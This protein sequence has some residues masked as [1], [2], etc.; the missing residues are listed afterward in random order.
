MTL[1][2]GIRMNGSQ[3]IFNKIAEA[4]LI[5]YTS[6]YYVNA[7]TNE[8]VWYSEDEQYHSLCIAQQGADFFAD[9]VKDAD[10]V[11]YEE[12]KHIFMKDMTKEN[13]LARMEKGE[14]QSIEYRLM[15][16]GKPVY[17]TVRLI[18]GPREGDEYFILGVINIDEEV[19]RRQKEQ[20]LEKE[21]R[22]YNQI[23][24]SL[25]EHYDT[26]YYVDIETDD[27]FEV[28][29]S[30]VYKSLEIKPSG[31]DFFG[32]SARNLKRAIYPEDA[33][34][35]L[36]LFT[37]Q[38]IIENLK[39]SKTFTLTYRL[40]VQGNVMNVRCSQIWANDRKHLILCIENINDEVS[41]QQEL[42]ESKRK[43]MTYGQIAE[44]LA[45]HYDVIY[46][47]DSSNDSYTG[48]TI[49]SIFGSLYIKE[50]GGD[51]FAEAWKNSEQIIYSED[52]DR[53]Q[54]I[55]GKDYLIS[56]LEDKK[57]FVCDYRMV[58]DGKMT[59]NRMTIMWASDRVHFIIGVQNIDEE[60]KKEK[61]QV[62]AL[63]RANELARRDDLTGIRNK[64]AYHELEEQVQEIIDEGAENLDFAI[65]VCDINGLKHV[66]DT[67][68]HKAGDEYIRS[69]CKIICNI[70]THS[71]V[72]RIGGDEFVV[73]IEK[74]SYNDRHSLLE[75]L[76]SQVMENLKKKSGP[77]IAAGM[78]YFE[79]SSDRKVS[80]VFD[81]AD[82][83]MYENKSR[84]KELSSLNVSEIS[85]TGDV[86]MPIPKERSIILDR[87][88]EALSVISDSMFIF[89]C[90]LKH[91]YSRWSKIGVEYFGMPSEYMYRA[92]DIWVEKIHPDDRATY[93]Q[94]MNALF[95][96]E[97][98][99]HN[100][101]YRA[102]RP[103]GE[104]D[105][106][107]CR[108]IVLRDT[109]GTPDY[110]C[111]SI[112]N[113]NI[114]SHV[115]RL[116][117]LRNQY[118][119]FED[120]QWA[121]DRKKPGRIVL[122][123]ISRFSEINEI[124]GY[125]FG[126]SVLQ[127][128]GRYL[129]ESAGNTG[130]VYRLDGT[131]FAIM[132]KIPA[133]EIERRYHEFRTAFRA[134][135]SVDDKYVILDLNA[136]FI[137]VDNF[138]VDHRTV[139]ACL[140]FAYGESKQRRQGDIVEFRNDLNDE[141]KHRLEKLHVIRASIMKNYEGF[142]LLYQPVV[143]SQTE[144]LVGAEALL[145]WRSDE[146]GI[147]PPDHFIPLLEKDP[148]FPELGEWIIRTAL[149]DAKKILADEP[150]FMINV[151]LSYTQLEKTDFTDMVGRILDETG[152]P[153]EHLCFEITERCR[154]LDIELLKNIAVKLRSRG[155][156]IALDDFGTG[157]SS[158]S[159][160]KNLP[161]NYIKIDRS[162]VRRIEEDDK[163]R[164]L[165][166]SF[167]VVASTFGAEVCVEGIETEGMKA[168]LQKYSVHSFQGYY[169]AK[170]LSFEEFL[171]WK[172]D[173]RPE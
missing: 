3:E 50:E 21:R 123:G 173:R 143:D 4:L 49:N 61:E 70:F 127:A 89:I 115:D 96:G 5:D 38:G 94:S 119:F 112:M 166:K 101:Q 43:S 124:Y 125:D 98:L 71:P 113:H 133:E 129:F 88:F 45:S 163:D 54:N 64:T 131:K 72:F 122:I 76:H 144:K 36:P 83:K 137:N 86:L 81:R 10:N 25:A 106:C 18:R 26:I 57:Q 116:T 32:E 2:G 168:I 105:V 17:H 162:F 75:R 77:V 28:S 91:D 44:S 24:E 111:G 34:R 136:G 42:K 99:F 90:D 48:F 59:Y 87:L 139:Y 120:V 62:T 126:N 63:N 35:T 84:L 169:Y 11:I 29:S 97:A 79:R 69:A 7:V 93:Q 20:E 146:Y 52:K 60:I 14:R 39:K 159:I 153:P 9:L 33:E 118:G 92:G 172:E 66:N 74:D 12:D 46:Y 85:D 167:A 51:F 68:G 103:D 134:G 40:M 31:G 164:K 30:D 156:K 138:N 148:L 1:I 114:H 8:Y 121:L 155:V 109:D 154:L 158:I 53:I 145:R 80:D 107:T 132:T 27:Y 37:K 19:R 110:F 160:V 73:F 100:M 82:T 15:I 117:G 142:Y 6:V 147:V 41:T 161:L 141:N 13:L 58:L 171:T 55:L 150:D 149:T 65:V 78:A 152:Y 151:N 108:G 140:N 170:P 47:I 23:S 16:D 104:Y 56:A 135:T 22:I 128:V 157:F 130:M 165:I 67:Q 95:A 102:Q